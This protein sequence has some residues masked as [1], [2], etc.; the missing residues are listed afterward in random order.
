MGDEPKNLNTGENQPKD[1]DTRAWRHDKQRKFEGT[2]R[3]LIKRVEYL[4]EE[5]LRIGLEGNAQSLGLENPKVLVI[6]AYRILNWQVSEGRVE[7][8]EGNMK[9]EILAR[10][11]DSTPE[12][13][14]EASKPKS[15]QDSETSTIS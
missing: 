5:D 7:R 11:V 6:A 15:E 12:E 2:V 1:L 10:A 3:S 8:E 4:S 9:L 13:I 14:M